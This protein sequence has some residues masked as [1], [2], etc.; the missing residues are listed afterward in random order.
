M[1][2]RAYGSQLARI[3]DAR[4]RRLAS[5]LQALETARRPSGTH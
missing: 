3:A 5:I 1:V 2:D 4:D